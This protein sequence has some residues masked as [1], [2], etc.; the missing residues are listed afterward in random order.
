MLDA[1]VGYEPIRCDD[2]EGMAL[3]GGTTIFLALALM[4]TGATMWSLLRR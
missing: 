2:V 1:L 3:M 4:A